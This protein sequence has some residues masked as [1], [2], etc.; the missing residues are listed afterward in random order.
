MDEIRV[1]SGEVN[2]AQLVE[3]DT[4]LNS[5]YEHEYAREMGLDQRERSEKVKGFR[6]AMTCV[7]EARKV[8]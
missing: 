5:E 3:R 7:K 8:E 6:S 1:E 2:I 4:G